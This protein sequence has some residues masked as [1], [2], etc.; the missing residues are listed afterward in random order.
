MIRI[1][2][3]YDD[4]DLIERTSIKGIEYQTPGGIDRTMGVLILD[5]V[6]KCPEIGLVKLCLEMLLPT[7][8]YTYVHY[9]FG[10]GVGAGFYISWM[11]ALAHRARMSSGQMLAWISPI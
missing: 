10:I 6:R 4:L 3:Y 11:P 7:G 8:V 1:L 5:K 9:Y 2:P